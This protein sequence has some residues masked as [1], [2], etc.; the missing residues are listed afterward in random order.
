M[1]RTLVCF[2]VMSVLSMDFIASPVLGAPQDAGAL[3]SDD[4][5]GADV[6]PASSVFYA[7]MTRVSGDITTVL[8]HPVAERVV[9]HAGWAKVE[10]SQPWK[11]FIAGRTFFELQ[12]GGP[13][14][15]VVDGLTAGGVYIAYDR[16]TDGLVIL[17]KA[18]SPEAMEVFRSK[19]LELGRL[20]KKVD[21]E[22]DSYRDLAIYRL[23]NAAA[24]VSG[25]WLLISNK[26]ELGRFVVDR[27]LKVETE[28]SEVLA[29]NETFR[30]AA[31]G[32]PKELS[33]WAWAGLASL[34]ED[35]KFLEGLNNKS[36][37]PLAE[38]LVGGLQSNVLHA[39]Y[40]TAEIRLP[41]TGPEFSVA[42][43]ASSDWIPEERQWYFGP[44]LSGAAPGLPEAPETLLAIGTWRDVSEMWLRAGD[45]F[46]EQMNDQLANA[47]STLTTLFAGKDFGED[48]LGSFEPQMGI[49]VTRQSFEDVLPAPAIRLPAF[50]FVMELRDPETMTRELRRTFQNMIGFFNVVGAMEGRPQLEMDIDKFENGEMLTSAYVPED[51]V[52]KSTSAD[53]IF[54]FSPSIGFSGKRCVIASTRSLASALTQSRTTTPA[55]DQ[56]NSYV[57]FQVPVLRDVLND[58]REQLISQNMLEQGNSRSTA[59]DQISLLLEVVSC[60]R[61]VAL[62]MGHSDGMIRIDGEIHIEQDFES[63]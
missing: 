1:R 5:T 43:P 27:L 11:N 62:K 51:D 15:K 44:E 58:N 18:A 4:R 33:A 57:S 8:N 3:S 52:A 6:F 7:E 36:E 56:V 24:V 20:G 53:L 22:K 40:V 47:D 10:E 37:N 13:W 12:M 31:T 17:V 35:E 21:P 41:E 29:S 55:I 14:D 46:D 28:Q 50:A 19:V 60:F 25:P 32:K 61:D 48:I 2:A 9:Q 42:M 45:L 26:P 30:A 54:N 49:I 63:K 23:D 16:Q 39:P 34:R 59:E 38:L